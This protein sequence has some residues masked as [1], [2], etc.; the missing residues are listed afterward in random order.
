MKVFLN[1]LLFT[2]VFALVSPMA[3]Q[4]G[5]VPYRHIVLFKFKDGT[6]P[7]RVN[8]IGESA[9]TLLQQVETVTGFEWGANVSQENR[10][11]G[12][13]HCLLLTFKDRAGVQAYLPHPKHKEFG[14]ELGDS[15]DKILVIDIDGT[16]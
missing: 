12:Y 15:A 16:K 14:K 1:S 10:S 4:A 6:S 2:L 5:D 3:A 9:R 13:T 11:Q 8:A 7:E